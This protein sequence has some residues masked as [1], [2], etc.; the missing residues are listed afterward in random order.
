MQGIFDHSFPLR[1]FLKSIPFIFL[2]LVPAGEV[3]FYENIQRLPLAEGVLCFDAHLAGVDPMPGLGVGNIDPH[4]IVLE[5]SADSFHR[6]SGQLEG[7]ALA[8]RNADGFP[9]VLVIRQL[10]YVCSAEA[11]AQVAGGTADFHGQRFYL[12]FRLDI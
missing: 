6:Y 8:G 4:R 1:Q 5:G 9:D 11:E 7:Q 12:N 10:F 2:W 3:L